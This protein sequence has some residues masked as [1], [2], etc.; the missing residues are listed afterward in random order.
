MDPRTLKQMIELLAPTPEQ[1]RRGLTR[2]LQEERNDHPMRHLK[3]TVVVGVVAALMLITCATAAVVIGIDQRLI[4]FLGGGQQAQELLAPGAQPVDATAEDNGATLHVTQILMDR[5]SILIL[6]DFT[7]PEG[8]VL[9]MAEDV[10][11]DILRGFSGLDGSIPSLLDSAGEPIDLDQSWT[12]NVNVLDDGDPLDNHLTLLSRMELS[13]GIQ[14]DWDI[15]ELSMPAVDLI[16]FDPEAE[17]IVTVYSGDWSCQFPIAWQDMGRSMQV[18]QVAGQVDDVN[19]SV[20][21]IYLSPM[22]LQ[23]H[24]ERETPVQLHSP[25]AVGG[26][27]GR[28]ISAVNVDGVTLTTKDGKTVPLTDMGSTVSDREQDRSFQLNEI[29]DLTQLQ[30]LTLRVGESNFDIPLDGLADGTI[31]P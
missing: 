19:I 27:D 20:T 18:D 31:K 8:T 22:T 9:D 2:L 23:F 12:Y 6:S 26:V 25:E 28:W 1:E 14:P 10:R 7:A 16:R 17:D 15:Q 13:E 21:D 3:K 24:L 11:G 30:T 29:T 5:Y 4:D